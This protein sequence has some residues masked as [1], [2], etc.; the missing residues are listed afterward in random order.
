MNNPIRILL[1]E[2][3][4]ADARF[5]VEMLK[6]AVAEGAPFAFELVH[7][8]RLDAALKLLDK[9]GVDAV[10]MDLDLPDSRGF[11][12]FHRV[13]AKAPDV[14]AV[15]LT[16]LADEDMGVRAVK[17][18]AQDYLVKGQVDGNIL[19]RAVRYSVERQKSG[20]AGKSAASQDGTVKAGRGAQE[21]CLDIIG[22]SRGFR[23][24]MDLVSVVAKTSRTSVL[25]HG[26]TGTGKELIANSIHYASSRRDGPLIKLNCSAI[27]DTLLE[28]EMFG[29]E[30]GAFTDAKQSKKGLFELADGG[31]IFLDEIGDMDIR[32][33]PKL[34]QVIE[35]RSLRKVGG[36]RDL[37]VDVRVIAATNKDLETMVREN[38]F[39][40]DLYYRL[41]VMD[42]YL[43][44][45]RER[46]EDILPL[47][48][49]F[50]AENCKAHGVETKRLSKECCGLLASHPW[51]GNARE[52]RNIIERAVILSDSH[53]ILPAHLP[54][55]LRRET[56]G[57]SFAS[58]PFSHG[59]LTLEELG[60]KYIRHVLD[61][62]NGNKTNAS[63]ILGISRL[64]LREKL[65]KSGL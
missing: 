53:E 55:E 1:I 65:K 63:E 25:I 17:E 6:D 2:D 15:V 47:A 22:R 38:R 58:N 32:L 31:T 62:V 5:V 37:Q 36:V 23:E 40:E 3:N 54:P 61:R 14:P 16:G 30:K 43:P 60:N 27:P 11:E 26:E 8:A 44:P 52:V 24:V 39:R 4:P 20:G 7:A 42:I 49:H 48:E 45:L 35:N 59:D 19:S 10:L 50:V 57:S 56:P 9:G 18:G 29:Y 33:Q 12:T 46:K 64:T 51:P 41:K 13:R 28:T 34:L 21:P